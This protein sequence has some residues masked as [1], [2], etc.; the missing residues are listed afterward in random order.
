MILAGTAIILAS[1]V[2]I[3]KAIMPDIDKPKKLIRE[4][5]HSCEFAKSLTGLK[6]SAR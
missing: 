5:E 2:L 1:S 4:E 3:L 6:I